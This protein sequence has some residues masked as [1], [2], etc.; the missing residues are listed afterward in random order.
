MLK[1]NRDNEIENLVVSFNGGK[2]RN[3]LIQIKHYLS[4]FLQFFNIACQPIQE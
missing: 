4:F 1:E 2:N 3:K